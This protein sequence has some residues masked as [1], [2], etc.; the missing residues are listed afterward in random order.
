MRLNYETMK[1]DINRLSSNTEIID[2]LYESL[3][4]SRCNLRNYN[5]LMRIKIYLDVEYERNKKCI[6]GFVQGIREFTGFKQFREWGCDL[7]AMFFYVDGGVIGGETGNRQK[8]LNLFENWANNLKKTNTIY[9][10]L[11]DIDDTLYPNP[12]HGTGIAGM[13]NSWETKKSYPGIKTFY[14]KF[15][16]KIRKKDYKYTTLLSATPGFKK[17]S[18]FKKPL[19]FNNILRKWSFI[20]GME[21]ISRLPE[22]SIIK[23]ATSIRDEY[24][25]GKYKRYNEEKLTQLS[26]YMGDLKAMRA[27]QYKR[28][29]PE[30]LLIFIG[31]NGQGDVYAAKKLLNDNVIIASYMHNIFV[32]DRYKMG[33]LRNY[34]SK[35]VY[36]KNYL[37]LANILKNQGLFSHR[38]YTDVLNSVKREFSKYKINENKERSMLHYD[39]KKYYDIVINGKKYDITSYIKFLVPKIKS[40]KVRRTMRKGG[41]KRK[42]RKKSRKNTR[43]KY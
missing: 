40:K 15:Y 9:H 14:E 42:K 8:L 43:K 10:I 18:K 39:G 36:F 6:S 1:R 3:L 28:L 21:D 41:K 29:F 22:G 13:D 38:D 2:Y 19:I 4:T 16:N 5:V 37:E 32:N 25:M 24:H 23:Q 17:M 31:D 34:K 27:K 35:I 20:H 12:E 26:K 30:Y 7:R 33:R 11:T